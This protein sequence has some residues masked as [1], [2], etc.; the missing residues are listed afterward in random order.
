VQVAS[1]VPVALT[2]VAV[3]EEHEPSARIVGKAIAFAQ[4]SFAGGGGGIF[5]QI[6]KTDDTALP[7]V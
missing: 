4:A 2:V 1:A 3:T 5:R 7:K 6:V